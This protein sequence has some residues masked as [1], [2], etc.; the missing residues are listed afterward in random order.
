MRPPSC[1]V[2][3]L[4]ASTGSSARTRARSVFTWRCT[5]KDAE[6]S[7]RVPKYRESEPS[8]QV[9]ADVE[10]AMQGRGRRARCEVAERRLDEGPYAIEGA[11]LV[12]DAGLEHRFEAVK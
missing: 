4:N 8:S 9:Q 7:L 2:S 5:T 11:R 3:R 12:V 6:T 1:A 10:P